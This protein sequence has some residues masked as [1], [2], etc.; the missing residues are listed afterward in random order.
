MNRFTHNQ[1]NE[2]IDRH[3]A[4]KNAE[5]LHME[6]NNRFPTSPETAQM[7]KD[8]Y[9]R[10]QANLAK[11]KSALKIP[12]ERITNRWDSKEERDFDA[13]WNACRAAM[14]AASEQAK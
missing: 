4:E 2:I 13:G 5:R 9:M 8:A 1:Y 10:G 14:L 12:D 11:I 3:A 6:I 7:A